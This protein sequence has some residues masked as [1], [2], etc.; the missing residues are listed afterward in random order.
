[1]RTFRP[2]ATLLL[3]LFATSCIQ[4]TTAVKPPVID[5]AAA[6][7]E[8]IKLYDGNSD[9]KLDK[10]ELA[11]SSLDLVMWDDDKD[12]GITEP[13]ISQRLQ[14]FIDSKVGLMT[15][16]CEVSWNGEP[17][18]GAKVEFEPEAF[19]DGGVE[20]SSGV[21]NESGMAKICVAEALLPHPSVTGIQPGLYKVRITHPEIPLPEKYNT[22]TTL[23]Y[24]SSPIDTLPQP[25]FD[26]SK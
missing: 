23:T 21:T 6:A 5:P 8:A 26:L 12:G 4:T 7:A 17:L 2:S 13:E 15:T 9:G 3:L 20:P 24:E 22:A 14:A 10:D 1:M 16:T 11:V 18:K 25:I 19:F